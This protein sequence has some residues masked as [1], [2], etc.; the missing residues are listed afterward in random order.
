MTFRLSMLFSAFT[1]VGLF[2]VSLAHAQANDE[3][4]HW[5]KHAGKSAL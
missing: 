2:M 3:I 1:L 4:T 5:P